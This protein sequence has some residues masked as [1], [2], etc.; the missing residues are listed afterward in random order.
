M[1][2]KQLFVVRILRKKRFK[3]LKFW[4]AICILL[5]SIQGCM[6]YFNKKME[7]QLR[8]VAKQH[9]G[10]AINNIVKQVIGNLKYDASTLYHMEKD[11][12]GNIVQ[13]QFDSYQLNQLL[14]KA[15]ETVDAS[16]LAAQDGKKDPTTQQVFYEEGVVYEVPL[17]YFSN[18]FFL[19]SKG[20]KLKIKIKM[21]ND[22]TGEIK[23]SVEPY[24]INSSLLKITLLLKIDAEVL[25]LLSSSS[26]HDENEVPLVVQVISG[27]VPSYTP[28]KN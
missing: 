7:P 8:A 27:N 5:I 21:M 3:K 15:L 11:T 25:T 14:Y 13:I 18:M 2:R 24:G 6:K 28:Y 22:V 23:T 1:E 4:L 10:F 26:L 16:L 17:G 20:P 19:Y 12:N 9:A